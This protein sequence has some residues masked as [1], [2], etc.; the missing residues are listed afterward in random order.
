[1]ELSKS[2]WLVMSMSLGAG[3][4][5]SKHVVRAGDVAGSMERF[6]ML[7]EKARVRTGQ[8]FGCISIQEAGLDGFWFQRV[9]AG[10][11]IES[12]LFD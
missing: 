4:R 1:M 9:L 6:A 11:G 7:H 2:T 8:C 3:E 12:Y 10:E 5:M